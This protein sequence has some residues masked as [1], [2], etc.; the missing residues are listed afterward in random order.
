MKPVKAN[1]QTNNF[2]DRCKAVLLLWIIYIIS[3]LFLLCFRVRLFINA[4]WSPSG[5]GLTSRLSFVM[6]NFETVTF[7]LVSW[8][9]CGARL[10]RFLMFSSFLLWM[11]LMHP[12]NSYRFGACTWFQGTNPISDSHSVNYFPTTTA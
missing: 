2:T 7:P 3:V 10:N 4:L 11:K 1:Q 12:L 6:S 5:K 9:R 8:V